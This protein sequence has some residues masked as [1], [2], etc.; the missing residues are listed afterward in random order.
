MSTS[1]KLCS[2]ILGWGSFTMSYC[3]SE[4]QHWG[5]QLVALLWLYWSPLGWQIKR[6]N[7]MVS[8]T[9]SAPWA[10]AESCRKRESGISM[11]FFSRWKHEVLH[12]LWTWENSEQPPP[13]PA[14]DITPQLITDCGN[15]PLD[16]RRLG[17]GSSPLFLQNPRLFI[18]K[19]DTKFTFHLTRGLP[20]IYYFLLFNP[21]NALLMLSLVQEWYSNQTFVSWRY[22]CVVT[23]NELN[24]RQ[25]TR[26]DSLP[27]SWIDF[28][29]CGHT[30]CL[31]T[32][33]HHIQLSITML[34]YSARWTVNLFSHD[35]LWL[36]L[37]VEGV[38]DQ[39]NSH[40]SAVACI[41]VDKYFQRGN[42]WFSCAMRHTHQN[43]NKSLFRA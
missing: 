24:H 13:T 31:C 32:F 2:F 33:S 20:I 12:W 38:R 17:F 11:K 42:F 30:S 19:W 4:M 16:L 5:N 35:L 14:D 29:D 34:W 6:N 43:L 22:Q 9:F 28:C 37:L 39:D 21:R 1:Y 27:G 8:K 3:I 15:L 23:F 40:M 7:N 26:R 10:A 36:N 18:S 25:S 41:E